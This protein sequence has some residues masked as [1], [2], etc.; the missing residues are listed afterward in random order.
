MSC[1]SSDSKSREQLQKTVLCGQREEEEEEKEPLFA[2]LALRVLWADCGVLRRDGGDDAEGLRCPG[3]AEIPCG[4][5][6]SGRGH[7][8]VSAGR[9]C[10]PECPF[11]EDAGPVPFS[12]VPPFTLGRFGFSCSSAGSWE[13][14]ISMVFPWLPFSAS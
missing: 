5:R 14:D 7:I 3:C 4:P 12:W 2:A 1:C 13:G 11:W 9:C 10:R 6:G 8:S